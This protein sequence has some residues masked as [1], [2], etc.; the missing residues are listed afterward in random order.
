MKYAQQ[1]LQDIRKQVG[2]HE[3]WKGKPPHLERLF[4]QQW[5]IFCGEGRFDPSKNNG[6]SARSVG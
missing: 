5:R 6:S 2:S 4:K 3:H 1:L